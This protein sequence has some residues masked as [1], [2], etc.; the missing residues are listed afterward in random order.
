LL[1]SADEAVHHRGLLPLRIV[2]DGA[3]PVIRPIEIIGLDQILAVYD[4]VDHALAG[5]ELP[6]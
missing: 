3:R 4:S 1:E 2:V 6:L 5:G